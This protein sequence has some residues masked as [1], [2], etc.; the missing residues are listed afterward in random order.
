MGGG[1]FYNQ[2]AINMQEDIPLMEQHEREEPQNR[3][4]SIKPFYS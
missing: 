4:V 1:R 3:R 2:N